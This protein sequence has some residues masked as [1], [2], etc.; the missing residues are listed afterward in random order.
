MLGSLSMPPPDKIL[1]LM[2]LFRED[3]RPGKIDLGVGVY[4]DA[5]GVTPVLDTVKEAER[6]L[7]AAET[8]KTYVGP[9]GDVAFTALV[10]KLVFGAAAPFERIRGIQTTGGAGAL[11]VIAGLV[12][13]ARPGAT[14]HVPDPTW[15][16]HAAMLEDHGLRL[17][18]YPYFSP[19]IEGRIDIDAMAAHLAAAPRGDVVLM[20]GCCH[21]PTGADLSPGQWERIAGVVARAGLVPFVDLAY[22]GFG[23]G[24]D[25]DAAGV[26]LLATLVPEMMVAVSCSK[27]FSIY[28]DR[29]GAAFVLAATAEEAAVAQSHMVVRGRIAYSMPPDHGASIVRII[30]EDPALA[31]RW[32]QEVD[33]MRGNVKALRQSLADAF[34]RLSNRGDFDHLTTDKG[35]FSRLDLTPDAVKRLREAHAIYIVEDGRINV[36]GLRAEEVDRFAAAVLACR[37]AAR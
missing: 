37:A 29:A 6:R 13:A 15:L 36:A 10:A 24:L 17:A 27:N 33:A 2:A 23:D 18:V 31:G 22:Q 1:S 21:N 8:T 26:R 3:P 12:A 16:N 5:T 9:A 11:S 28:R 14:V 4:R 19:G 32:R 20:H 34:R 30:L 7:H 25:E 35:M